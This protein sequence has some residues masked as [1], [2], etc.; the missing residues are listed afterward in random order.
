MSHDGAVLQVEFSSLQ[1]RHRLGT[2]LRLLALTAAGLGRGHALVIGKS[3]AAT[4]TAPPAAESRSLLASYLALYAVGMQQPLPALPRVCSQ[5]AALRLAERDP[6]DPKVGEP[7]LRR[8]WEYDS[9]ENWKA[10]FDYRSMLDLPSS[11]IALPGDTRGEPFLVGALGQL[12][13][14]PLLAREGTP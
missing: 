1:A 5:W 11:A 9:D 12:I 13:W 8:A 14:Q 3:R 4:L 7:L 10:F 2:W 6:R